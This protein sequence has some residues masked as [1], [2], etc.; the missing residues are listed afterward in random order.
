MHNF[1]FNVPTEIRFGR[2]REKEI[3]DILKK[4]NISKVLMIYGTSS[5]KSN[6]L[7]DTVI[8]ILKESKISVIEYSGIKSNPRLSDVNN[9]AKLGRDEKVE[10][11]LAVGGGSVMDSGK[12]IAAAIEHNCNAWDFYTGTAITKA[13]P[14]Y[15][16]VTLSATASEMNFGF[17]ITNDETKEK[18]GNGANACFP[19]V[20]I[21]NPEL[22]ITV[23]PNYTAF[24]A[25]DII[26]HTIEGYLTTT[27]TTTL[28]DKFNESIIKSVIETTEKI[29]QNPEDYN[30]RAEF[31]W[32]A[33]MALN[34]TMNLGRE[35]VAFPNHM[36][37]HGLS[38]VTDIPH[39]AGLSIIIP[40]WMR[41]YKNKNETQFMKFS[42]EIF[43]KDSIDAGIEA[44]E[45]WF[46]SIGCPIRLSEYNIFEEQFNEIKDKAFK[47]AQMWGMDS[48]YTEDVIMEILK[49]AK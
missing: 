38:G 47:Q 48:Y 6:G 15:N 14:I 27:S 21:L 40:A 44:L 2:N 4:D 32:S 28:I 18:M 35:G 22:T 30:S 23:P 45:N 42:K 37:E 7:Y 3:G 5:I 34:G 36:I 39:G 20:S 19:K 13:L 1:D 17:V 33:T 29:L 24:G 43:N 11:V 8:S 26:A 16:I 10:A 9:A 31:M 46:H 25:V 12:A 41:W 49:L